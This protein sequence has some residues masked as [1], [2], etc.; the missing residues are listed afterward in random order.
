MCKPRN[1]GRSGDCEKGQ[2]A[3]GESGRRSGICTSDFRQNTC[4]A[5]QEMLVANERGW[6]VI[7]N[8]TPSMEGQ[9]TY[10]EGV[11][12][13]RASSVHFGAEHSMLGT[14]AYLASQHEKGRQ[15]H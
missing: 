1:G 4:H 7:V 13:R 3:P 8:R 14:A 9:D 12:S 10:A 2:M 5:G 6:R 11:C 15:R